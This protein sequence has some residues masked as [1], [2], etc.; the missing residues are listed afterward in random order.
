MADMTLFL[1]Y[2]RFCFP[3]I[4]MTPLSRIITDHLI[5][6]VFLNETLTDESYS[7]FLRESLHET[8]RR[9]IV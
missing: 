5:E 3:V 7:S 8:V 2:S 6:P 1:N 4:R 9:H